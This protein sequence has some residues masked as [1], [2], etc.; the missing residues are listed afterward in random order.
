MRLQTPTSARRRARFV[1]G[2]IVASVIALG[3][4]LVQPGTSQAAAARPIPPQVRVEQLKVP[5]GLAVTPLRR[6]ATPAPAIAATAPAAATAATVSSAAPVTLDAGMDFSM[7]GVVCDTPRDLGA[8]LVRLRTSLDG[9]SWGPW[10]EAE[11][12][13]SDQAASAGESYIDPVW[14]R[15]ARYVQVSARA[16]AL[17][18][19]VVLANVRV[20][21]IASVP[22]AAETAGAAIGG[23]A[24]AATAGISPVSSAAAGPASPAAG[25]S[26]AE[27]AIVTRAQWGADES[28]RSGTPTYAAVK[29]AFVHHTDTGNDYTTADAPAIVRAIYAYHTQTLGWSDIGYDF[30]IDRFGTIYE[31]RYGGV[32]RGVVGAQVLGFN[33][34]STGISVI[35]TY[36]TEAPPVEAMTSLE[37]LLAW[38]LSLGG[39]NAQGTATMKCGYTEKF[40]AGAAVTLPVI[41]GH[42]D[43]NYTEC[44]GDAL[45]AQLPVVRSAVWALMHPAPWAVTLSVS[46]TSIPAYGTVT[47]AGAVTGVAGAPAAGVVT[48][49][50]RPAK[51]GDWIAWRTATLSAAGS[52]AVSV[53]MTSPN[54]WQFRTEMPATSSMLAGFSPIQTLTVTKAPWRV[55]LG[56]SRTAATVGKS[57][58]YSGRVRTA[59][60]RAGNGVVTIQRR[61]SSSGGWRAWRTVSLNARGGYVVTVRMT[62][63]NSWQIRARKAATPAAPVG[64]STVKAVRVF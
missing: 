38:K 62:R 30:L 14:V 51:G 1:A 42:R 41:A 44:P 39:L 40:K 9:V 55:S 63:R 52:Y 32:S 6:I 36:T 2:L 60:G 15:A 46:A 33:T 54:G 57:V 58:R 8:V 43:A 23:A 10:R 19:P 27:P 16:A 12:Q 34:G 18:A 45:Y 22:D 48:L 4:V 59:A 20:A 21:A 47:Y 29:M 11:L 13:Q 35:G 24:S 56:V 53:K 28:L 26:P 7:A 61:P 49:Q 5:G 31:G 3:A 50:R 17:R 64:F 37:N 25:V